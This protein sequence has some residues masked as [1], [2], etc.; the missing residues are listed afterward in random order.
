MLE[1]DVFKRMSWL[2]P[3]GVLT[4]FQAFMNYRR[5][6]T[7]GWSI[8]NVLMDF[9]GGLFSILQMF[10]QSYNNGEL[11][12]LTH[13]HRLTS[14]LTESSSF[15]RW[16]EAG[17]RRP[18]EVWPWGFFCVLRRP[19][20]DSALLPLPE[21]CTVRSHPPVWRLKGDMK[22]VGSRSW[23]KHFK[24]STLGQLNDIF[25]ELGKH[26]KLME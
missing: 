17:F 23:W 2:V 7:E 6:S 19:V 5:Q 1:N 4:G 20:P 8:G 18:Y 9:S 16:V 14:C 10:L 15:S 3:A 12:P 26:I 22:V 24:I 11:W 25:G 21:E 13:V